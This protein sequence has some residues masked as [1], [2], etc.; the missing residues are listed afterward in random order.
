MIYLTLL[1]LFTSSHLFSQPSN[2]GLDLTLQ[3]RREHSIVKKLNQ[4]DTDIA[5]NERSLSRRKA[6]LKR[7][8]QKRAQLM[9]ELIERRVDR[10][11]NGTLPLAKQ[12]QFEAERRALATI[13][14]EEKELSSQAQALLDELL[15]AITE[16]H[17]K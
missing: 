8:R 14:Q 6:E 9:L 7:I 15:R 17:R 2:P 16:A 12:Q 13:S 11:Q 5:R 10:L 1:L 3:G 4:L